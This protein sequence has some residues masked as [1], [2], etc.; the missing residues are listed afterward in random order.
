MVQNKKNPIKKNPIKN[1]GEIRTPGQFIDAIPRFENINVDLPIKSKKLLKFIYE[2]AENL[3]K[4]L[5]DSNGNLKPPLIIS[6]HPKLSLL[7]NNVHETYFAQYIADKLDMIPIWIPYIYDTGYKTVANKIRLPTYVFFEDKYIPIR[8]SA[9]IRGN[10]MATEPPLSEKEIKAFFRELEKHEIYILSN[11]KN[12]LNPFNFGHYLFDLKKRVMQISPKSIRKKINSIQTDWIKQVKGS[13]RLA[14]SLA[15]ISLYNLKKMNINIALLNIDDILADIVKIVFE[16]ILQTPKIK[17]DPSLLEN[18]FLAYNLKTKERT[19]ILYAGDL[20]FIGFNEF[21]VKVFDGNF[22][23][24]IQGIREHSVLPT[25]HLIMTLFTAMGCRIVLGGEHTLNYYPNYFEKSH[26]LLEQTQFNSKMFLLSYGN[27]RFIDLR[28]LTDIMATIRI[29]DKVGSRNYIKK[30]TFNV[31][32]DIID[33]LNF[34]AG[35]K[36]VPKE[37]IH[38]IEKILNKNIE[39]IINSFKT[40]KTAYD[41]ELA[42]NK[43]VHNILEMKPEDILKNPSILKK[44]IPDL[45]LNGLNLGKLEYVLDNLRIDADMRLKK[46]E[47]NI[48]F[49]K[50][51]L[52]GT[53][54][55]IDATE[56]IY[57]GILIRSNR[58]PSLFEMIFYEIMPQ[59]NFE[60]EGYFEQPSSNWILS[61][62]VVNKKKFGRIDSKRFDNYKDAFEYLIPPQKLPKML[63]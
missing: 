40:K 9:K 57:N 56:I 23:D 58:Y 17:Q 51:I 12:M 3:P 44:Y 31:P 36:N 22:D 8:A 24:L 30:G 21:D 19:P 18:L 6:F 63:R 14:D 33:H 20:H 45:N 42:R 47:E 37:Y 62:F 16:D 2:K 61:H 48:L 10:I 13:K 39:E 5:N 50:R 43:E 32:E 38:I 11:F 53:I 28:N 41:K 55:S 46:M 59:N 1:S 7:N 60:I 54:E 27:T 35:P 4:N 34:L 15:K 25:G 26:D 29:L 49:E 52:G